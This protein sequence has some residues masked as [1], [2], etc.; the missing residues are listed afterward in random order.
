MF[1]LDI[2]QMIWYYYEVC[3]Y[4]FREYEFSIK[5]L[6]YFIILYSLIVWSF[7]LNELH[8]SLIHKF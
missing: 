4:I 6:H 8:Y 7:L 2:V 3:K 5:I 1:L